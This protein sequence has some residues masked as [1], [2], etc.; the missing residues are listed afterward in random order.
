MSDRF[1]KAH[2]QSA[3]EIVGHGMLQH[4]VGGRISAFATVAASLTRRVSAGARECSGKELAHGRP[5][6]EPARGAL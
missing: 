2:G 6:P 1:V 5:V 3:A 4:E